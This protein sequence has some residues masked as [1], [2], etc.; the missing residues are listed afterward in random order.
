VLDLGYA[1]FVELR[2]GEVRLSPGPMGE[3]FSGSCIVTSR[4]PLIQIAVTTATKSGAFVPKGRSRG[5]CQ[6]L[7]GA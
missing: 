4:N 5:Y 2:Y 6:W 7:G 3:N 1:N